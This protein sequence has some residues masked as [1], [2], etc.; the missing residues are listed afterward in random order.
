MLGL[1]ESVRTPSEECSCL[2]FLG[3]L[4]SASVSVLLSSVDS[5]DVSASTG[6]GSVS[7][8]VLDGPVVSSLLGVE[9]TA[10]LGILSL[11][12]MEVGS[13]RES[14]DGMRMAILLSVG[15]S[16]SR[17]SKSKKGGLTP[18]SSVFIR[19]NEAYLPFFY[20]G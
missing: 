5:L 6:S 17:L 12:E 3:G 9:T 20:I 19:V 10:G 13:S 4:S 1:K 15:W 11:L 18:E 16:T 2:H 14:G 7:S 8:D